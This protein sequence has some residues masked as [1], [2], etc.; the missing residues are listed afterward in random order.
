M[1]DMQQVS[2]ALLRLEQNRARHERGDAPRFPIAS[3]YARTPSR[4]PRGPAMR[5]P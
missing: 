3:D 4:H 2:A 1:I 5:H